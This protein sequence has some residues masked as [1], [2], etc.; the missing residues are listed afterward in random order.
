MSQERFAATWG[1]HRNRLG[2]IEQGKK[3]SRLSM[4][5]LLAEALGLQP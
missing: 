5:M 4:V 3:D 1:M 2:H